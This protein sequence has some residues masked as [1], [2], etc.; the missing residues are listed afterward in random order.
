M[1]AKNQVESRTVEVGD[2]ADGQWVINK[3]LQKGDKVIV[4]GVAKIGPGAPVNVTETVA[5][6]PD[7]AANAPVAN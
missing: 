5:S 4:D 1:N 6:T 7:K 3:G 2:W